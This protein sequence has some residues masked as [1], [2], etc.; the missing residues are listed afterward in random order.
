MIYSHT[1][2]RNVMIHRKF[3]KNSKPKV[4]NYEKYSKYQE[5]LSYIL[6]ILIK[7]KVKSSYEVVYSLFL[8]LRKD[9]LKHLNNKLIMVKY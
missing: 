6:K 3:D 8:N 2:K 4:V 7:R 5:F 1:K 9:D